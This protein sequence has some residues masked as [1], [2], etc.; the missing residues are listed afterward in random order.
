MYIFNYKGVPFHLFNLDKIELKVDNISYWQIKKLK[1]WKSPN[2][3]VQFVDEKYFE[4]VVG[5]I[6]NYDE[7]IKFLK[8]NVLE[9]EKK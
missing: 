5:C 8:K 7:V 6:V 9:K 2:L 4:N 3:C 1:G